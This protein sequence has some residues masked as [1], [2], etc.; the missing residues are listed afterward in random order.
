MYAIVT[1][2][3]CSSRSLLCKFVIRF[4]LIDE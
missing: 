4:F 2:I 1:I 3:V